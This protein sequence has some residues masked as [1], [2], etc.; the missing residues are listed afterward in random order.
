M[1]LS[2]ER[3]NHE[4]SG[5]HVCK[6]GWSVEYFF[7]LWGAKRGFRKWKKKLAKPPR[8]KVIYEEELK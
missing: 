4:T 2:I 3:P 1:R 8:D 5:Y 7:T 6:D